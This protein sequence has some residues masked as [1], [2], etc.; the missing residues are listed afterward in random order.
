MN[1]SKTYRV[2]IDAALASLASILFDS[3]LFNWFTDAEQTV[4]ISVIVAVVALE[5]V[6]YSA[7]VLSSSSLFFKLV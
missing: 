3:E 1:E 2:R 7:K 4:L 5:F 6:S